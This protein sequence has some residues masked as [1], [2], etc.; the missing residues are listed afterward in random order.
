MSPVEDEP[1]EKAVPAEEVEDDEDEEGA[2]GAEAG[3]GDDAEAEAKRLAKA[4]KARAKKKAA[5]ER[6]KLAK[7]EGGDAAVTGA[8]RIRPPPKT[9]VTACL[10]ACLGS[11]L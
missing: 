6:A 7:A 10:G 8:I 3:G 2:E 5:K 1:V 11:L 4:A 9:V